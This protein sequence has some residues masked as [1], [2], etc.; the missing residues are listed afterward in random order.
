MKVLARAKAAMPTGILIKNTH[1][2]DRVSVSHPPRVGP[3]MGPSMMA[4]LQMLIT[5]GNICGGKR[6]SMTVWDRG[7]SDAPARP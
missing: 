7:M 6:S 5:R 3:A 4:A 1:R 2:Q